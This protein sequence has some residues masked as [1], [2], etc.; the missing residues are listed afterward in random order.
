[1]GDEYENVSNFLL[2]KDQLIEKFGWEEYFIFAL[3][4]GV[5][6]LF[7]FICFDSFQIWEL[8]EFNSL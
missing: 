1:M 7:L 8:T 2:S 3:M 4:L 6:L 5:R